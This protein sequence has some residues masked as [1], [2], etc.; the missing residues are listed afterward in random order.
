MACHHKG[1][2][3]MNLFMPLFSVAHFDA[4]LCVIAREWNGRSNLQSYR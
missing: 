3:K 4:Y 2:I 1:R